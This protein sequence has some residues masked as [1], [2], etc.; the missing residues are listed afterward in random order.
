MVAAAWG[1]TVNMLFHNWSLVLDKGL[2]S[3][4]F[5][6]EIPHFLKLK[7]ARSSRLIKQF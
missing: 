4:T 7:P 2:S 5:S 3:V 6:A 1:S